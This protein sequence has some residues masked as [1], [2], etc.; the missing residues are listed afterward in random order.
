[1]TYGDGAGNTKPLTSIDVAGHEMSHGV[2]E[3]T[4]ALVYRGDAGGLNEATSDIFG[5]EVEFYANNRGG[6]GRLPHRREDRH[7]R[8]RH[9]AALHGQAEQGRPLPGL[10]DVRDLPLDPHYS[11]G[12]LNHWFYLA[13]EGSGAKTVGG[14]AYNSPTCNGSTVTGIGHGVVAK[15][16][17][18]TLATKLTS[19]SDYQAAREGAIRSAK[20]ALRHR[21][22]RV[23]R[24]GEGVQRDRRPRG[25]ADLHQLSRAL[26]WAHRE[27][28]PG[29]DRGRLPACHGGMP[30]LTHRHTERC[31]D[32]GHVLEEGRD[33]EAVPDSSA[34]ERGPNPGAWSPR[35]R[36][37]Q[38]GRPRWS[39][40]GDRPRDPGQPAEGVLAHPAHLRARRAVAVHRAGLL[41]DVAVGEAREAAR[42]VMVTGKGRHRPG[43]GGTLCRRRRAG[44]QPAAQPRAVVRV[45]VAGEVG[46]CGH[47]AHHRPA[48]A[49]CPHHVRR[50]IV[51]TTACL[52][53]MPPP[54]PISAP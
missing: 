30:R 11:S 45:R 8:Q 1:M 24:R 25:H 33:D 26:I 6:P 49:S 44:R 32:L 14:V 3:N 54:R 34:S 18:R 2:T 39:R 40:A 10:L 35:P 29:P 5:T 37:R 50:R 43:V 12:P 20:G 46:A 7:Q 22:S 19:R 21:R 17:Y 52:T 42:A 27:G 41:D 9:P 28:A 47:P 13:S 16:W 38:G 53:G 15:I 4:A 31:P 48:G 36:G 51:P 23:R